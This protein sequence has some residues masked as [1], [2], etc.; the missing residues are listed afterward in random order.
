MRKNYFLLS[1]ILFI[2]NTLFLDAQ[3]TTWLEGKWK[4]RGYQPYGDQTSIW[5]MELN[6]YQK[7]GSLKVEISYPSLNCS[8]VWTVDK[9]EEKKA[10][11]NE[12]IEKGLLSCVSGNQCIVHP[13][14]DNHIIV[15]FV[16]AYNDPKE[17][18]STASLVKVPTKN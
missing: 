2:A 14:D 1:L 3:S 16:L 11:F 17:I 9:L 12:K 7:D 5:T 4:G 10:Y 15:T 18:L 8:G 13:I 6:V